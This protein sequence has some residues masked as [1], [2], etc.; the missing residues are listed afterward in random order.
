MLTNKVKISLSIYCL[1]GNQTAK[2]YSALSYLRQIER[3]TKCN[4]CQI[5]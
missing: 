5:T 1:K 4:Y 3:A 2:V